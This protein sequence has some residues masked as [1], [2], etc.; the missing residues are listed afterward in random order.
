[1]A[2]ESGDTWYGKGTP[3]VCTTWHDISTF[4]RARGMAWHKCWLSWAEN[5]RHMGLKSMTQLED[6]LKNDA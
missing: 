2:N 6:G 3:H 5:F 4:C 1:M